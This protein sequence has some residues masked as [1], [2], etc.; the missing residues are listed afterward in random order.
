[1]PFQF[2][3]FLHFSTSIWDLKST[4]TRPYRVSPSSTGVSPDRGQSCWWQTLWPVGWHRCLPAV[5]DICAACVTAAPPSSQCADLLGSELAPG[6]GGG[7]WLVC[8][9]QEHML[10]CRDWLQPAAPIRYRL[11][12]G[13][14]RG[15]MAPS[16]RLG[17]CPGAPPILRAE[18][19]M[20]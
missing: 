18:I 11:G 16:A 6:G 10:I 1:M 7:A 13:D 12:P 3:H 8:V 4:P 5:R 15:G 17:R 9:S 20:Q 19:T 14:I 2:S